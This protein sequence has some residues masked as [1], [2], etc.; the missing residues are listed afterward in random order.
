M[1]SVGR[2][3]GRM[4]YVPAAF[5]CQPMVMGG[6]SGGDECDPYTRPNPLN[7]VTDLT[8]IPV[9]QP[10]TGVITNLCAEVS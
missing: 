2:I 6:G 4:S 9:I 1:A 5:Y 7:I 3:G 10:A 8:V